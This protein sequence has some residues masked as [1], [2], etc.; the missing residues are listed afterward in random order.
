MDERAV[1]AHSFARLV[2]Y[3]IVHCATERERASF[4]QILFGTMKSWNKICSALY[5][6]FP[7]IAGQVLYAYINVYKVPHS[8]NHQFNIMIAIVLH[9]RSE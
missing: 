1:Y 3:I 9:R 7:H 6:L 4:G 5:T 8:Q 2:G